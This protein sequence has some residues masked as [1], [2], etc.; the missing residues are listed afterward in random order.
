MI[1]F[2]FFINESDEY[3]SQIPCFGV[4]NDKEEKICKENMKGNYSKVNRQF[5]VEGLILGK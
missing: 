1:L 5:R 4:E 2:F 3:K